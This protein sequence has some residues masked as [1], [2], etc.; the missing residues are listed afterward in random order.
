MTLTSGLT[1]YVLAKARN[2]HNQWSSVMASDGIRVAQGPL[3]LA[4]A[5][6]LPDG[7][8]VEIPNLVLTHAPVSDT[9]AVRQIGNMVGIKVTKGVGSLPSI[10]P[11]TTL[12]LAGRLSTNADTRE[13]T[14]A[15]VTTTGSTEIP[16]APL[17]IARDIGGL[18]YFYSAGP[19]VAGQKGS[20]WGIGLNNVG[21]MVRVIGEVSAHGTGKFYLDDGSPIPGGLPV[22][23]LPTV[24]RPG[25]GARVK[26]TAL[27]E[28]PGLLVLAQ[29]DIVPL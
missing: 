6:K 3:T 19:P 27:I 23:Y 17:L 7:K 13:L 8:W 20:P 18:D 12:T 29:T 15:I 26:L 28:S 11:G 25:I 21:L 9:M 4:E 2:P 22:S 14:D 5:K 16:C 24:T 1:Y 10:T